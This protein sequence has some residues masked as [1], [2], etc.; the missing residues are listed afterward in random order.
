MINDS[1]K[2]GFSS[3][4]EVY[5]HYCVIFDLLT[6]LCLSPSE[7]NIS[8]DIA[9]AMLDLLLTVLWCYF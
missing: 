8:L 4:W 9:Y 6:Y 7:F 5:I 2:T 3:L 1:N